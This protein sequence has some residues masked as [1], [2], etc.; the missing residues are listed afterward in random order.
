LLLPRPALRRP[1]LAA[2]VAAT[3]AEAHP[4]GV[5]DRAP[6]DL[7]RPQLD[8]VARALVVVCEALRPGAELESPG[9]QLMPSFGGGHRPEPRLAGSKQSR[10]R[11]RLAHRLGVLQHA[12][13]DHTAEQSS[14][15]STRAGSCSSCAPSASACASLADA[16]G[17]FRVSDG[18]GG[19]APLYALGAGGP[20]GIAASS[21]ITVRRS[22]RSRLAGTWREGSPSMLRRAAD[23]LSPVASSTQRCAARKTGS[24]SVMRSGG[25]LGESLTPRQRLVS[26]ASSVGA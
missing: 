7:E 24:D 19:R 21:T 11:H 4:A 5:A 13:S 26:P 6:A 2:L 23:L 25:G 8:G 12:A 9:R 17:V 22:R 15:A 16:G 20:P 10:D 3:V 14:A 1:P 18:M